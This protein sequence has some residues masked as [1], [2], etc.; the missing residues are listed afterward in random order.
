MRRKRLPLGEFEQ[1]VLLAILNL[2]ADAYA[3]SIARALED[4]TG[5]TVARGA[6]YTTLDRLEAKG[7]VRWRV[8]ASTERR[9]GLP[10]RCFS[11][12][13]DGIRALRTSREALQSL[14]DGLNE[15]LAES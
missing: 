4:S 10:K 1:H 3:S 7:I 14:L 5:R 9:S 15:A 2:G 12:T 6:V 11:V 13:A 8:E